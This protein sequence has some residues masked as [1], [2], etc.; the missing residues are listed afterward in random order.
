MSKISTIKIHVLSFVTGS[1]TGGYLHG[2]HLKT[3]HLKEM[4]NY[5]E[6]LGQIKGEI[7]RVENVIISRIKDTEMSPDASLVGD[8]SDHSAEAATWVGSI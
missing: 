8:C 1:I 7:N 3:R 2:S 4:D 6:E 5:H